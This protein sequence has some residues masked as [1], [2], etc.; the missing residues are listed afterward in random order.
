MLA[1]LMIFPL[2]VETVSH[3]MSDPESKSDKLMNPTEKKQAVHVSD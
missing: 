3:R 1:S 2:V